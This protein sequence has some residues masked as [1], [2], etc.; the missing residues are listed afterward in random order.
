MTLSPWF[1]FSLD[2]VR[3]F[4]LP[5][6]KWRVGRSGSDGELAAKAGQ[7]GV[8]LLW[9]C[10]AVFSRPAVV[11]DCRGEFWG[12][13]NGGTLKSTRPNPRPRHK[14]TATRERCGLDMV[15]PKGIKALTD[16]LVPGG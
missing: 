14:K 5:G 7:I 3:G 15:Y 12:G 13:H 1:L 2:I 11:G 6:G 8:G 4:L 16:L 10:W 9:V